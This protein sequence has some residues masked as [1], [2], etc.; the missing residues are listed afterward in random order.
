ME[1]LH[2]C[3]SLAVL[4]NTQKPNT[5]T[6]SISNGVLKEYHVSTSKPPIKSLNASPME[7]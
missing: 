2:V 5:R 4:V 3:Q 7:Y 6:H 1:L